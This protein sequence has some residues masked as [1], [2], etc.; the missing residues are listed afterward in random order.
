M[1]CKQDLCQAPKNPEFCHLVAC[2]IW[3][4]SPGQRNLSGEREAWGGGGH[5]NF[6]VQAQEWESIWK[7]LTV[8]TRWGPSADVERSGR[9]SQ[10]REQAP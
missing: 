10:S 3:E 2:R 4:L 1:Q 9:C 6:K 7:E 5:S 8:G